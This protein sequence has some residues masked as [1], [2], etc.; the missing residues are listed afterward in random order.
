MSLKR[1]L[2]VRLPH[3]VGVAVAGALVIGFGLMFAC[4]TYPTYKG[5]STD[6]TIENSYVFYDPTTDPQKA[7]LR[8]D[9]FVNWY[10][11]TDYTPDAGVSTGDAATNAVA[12]AALSVID[13]I[14]DGAVCGA[15]SAGVI[16]FSHNNDWGGLFGPWDFGT[17]SVDASAFDGIAFWARSPGNTTKGLTL[18]LNDTNTESDGSPGSC[19]NYT[20][21]GGVA[22]Q[23]GSGQGGID[24]STGTPLSG[25][26][27][28]RAPFPN[29]CANLYTVAIELTSDWSFYAIPFEDFQQSAKPNRVPNAVFAAGT[30]PGTGLLKNALRHF[31]LRLPKAAVAELWLAKLGF[32]KNKVAGANVDGGTGA[33]KL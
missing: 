12:F 18:S 15:T 1:N 2:P 30:V 20:I 19:Q 6:C 14:P 32:Y 26:G 9:N 16:L 13:P 11:S 29:E 28:A 5:L 8:L 23:Q 27:T 21:D 31:V 25:S 24:P 10:V 7:A 4:S 17:T 22:V 33:G 3:A